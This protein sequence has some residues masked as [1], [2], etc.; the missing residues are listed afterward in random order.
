VAV[1]FGI[2]PNRTTTPC[3]LSKTITVPQRSEGSLAPFRAYQVGP[4]VS[5]SQVDRVVELVTAAMPSTT[6]RRRI[7]S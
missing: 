6:T 1:P 3:W 4:V 7:E 5:N 2:P